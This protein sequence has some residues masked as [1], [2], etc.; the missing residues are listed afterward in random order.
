MLNLDTHVDNVHGLNMV[1]GVLWYMSS[2]R[3][4]LLLFVCLIADLYLTDVKFVCL[5]LIEVSVSNRCSV[6]FCNL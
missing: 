4:P 6:S 2:I 3:V 1:E 5:N